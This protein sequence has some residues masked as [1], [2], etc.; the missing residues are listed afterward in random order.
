MNVR[1]D[2]VGSW[3]II[4]LGIAAWG[5]VGLGASVILHWAGL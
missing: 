1:R 5:V 4:P 2:I 3:L